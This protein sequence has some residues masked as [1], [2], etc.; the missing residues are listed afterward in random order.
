MTRSGFSL[1]E[2]MLSIVVASMIGIALFM[3]INAIKVGSKIIEKNISTDMREQTIIN[4]MRKDMQAIF[5]PDFELIVKTE[6]VESKTKAVTGKAA[7]K[8]KQ[9]EAKKK[10]SYDASGLVI[11]QGEQGNMEFSFMTRNSVQPYG[12]IGP[13][14]NRVTYRLAKDPGHKHFCLTR[15]ELH[16]KDFRKYKR[17]NIEYK[18][19]ARS[20]KLARDIKTLEMVSWDRKKEEEKKNSKTKESYHKPKNTDKKI[21]PF[22]EATQWPVSKDGKNMPDLPHFIEC[23]FVLWDSVKESDVVFEMRVQILHDQHKPKGEKIKQKSGAKKNSTAKAFG[24]NPR[25]R[26]VR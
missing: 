15:Q 1:V 7:Q 20:Y 24:G 23:R 3:T 8:N 2:V 11:K 4:V 19:K 26:K 12:K 18:D 17:D 13:R 14:V 16:L 5:Y 21:Q 10:K 25:V 22:L 9:D 6:S